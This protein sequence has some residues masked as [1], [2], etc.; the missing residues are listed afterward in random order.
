MTSS[1]TARWRL[2]MPVDVTTNL[3]RRDD[4]ASSIE[5]RLRSVVGWLDRQRGPVIDRA[6]RS[7][8]T[9]SQATTRTL[10]RAANLNPVTVR[11]RRTEGR[12]RVALFVVTATI[13]TAA[14]AIVALLFDPDRGRSRR[15]YLRD[16]SAAV[17]RRTARR[18]DRGARFARHTVIGM[19]GAVRHGGRGLPADDVSLAHR[20]ETELFRDPTIDKGAINVNAEHGVVYLRGTA[21]SP[22]RI[23]EIAERTKRIHGVTAVENLLHVPGV[24]APTASRRPD[25]NGAHEPEPVG[26]QGPA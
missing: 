12:R 21:P 20:V 4:L 2:S 6:R 7:A 23:T 8:T 1:R 3:P 18:L 26:A 11:R 19:G 15:A 5:S 13:A 9:L 10:D 24:P 14:G 16:R 25:R 17:A 22:A